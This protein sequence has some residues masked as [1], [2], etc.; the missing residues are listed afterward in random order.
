MPW[1]WTDDLADLLIEHDGLRPETVTDWTQRPAALSAPESADA[2][3][4]ARSLLGSEGE[5]VA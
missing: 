2:L 5:A 1:F 3:D 4:F